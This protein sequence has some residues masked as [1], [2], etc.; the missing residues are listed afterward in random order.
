MNGDDTRSVVLS[1][2][3]ER[4]NALDGAEATDDV[5]ERS[6]WLKGGDIEDDD[7]DGVADGMRSA[8]W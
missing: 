4:T 2:F 6:F 5:E 3:F 7:E 1:T 8:G